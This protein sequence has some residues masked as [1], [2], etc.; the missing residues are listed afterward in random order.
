MQMIME[1]GSAVILSILSFSYNAKP[2]LPIW[3]QKVDLF[4]F[5]PLA[6]DN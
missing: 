6:D 1:S 4:K 2:H 3:R 5:G